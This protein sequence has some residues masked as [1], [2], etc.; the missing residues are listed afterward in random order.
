MK[1][2]ARTTRNERGQ[3]ETSSLCLPHPPSLRH[4][5]PHPFQH[6]PDLRSLQATAMTCLPRALAEPRCPAVVYR[7]S[8]WKQMFM[9]GRGRKHEYSRKRP[10]N[11]RNMSRKYPKTNPGN[12]QNNSQ[13]LPG[14][15]WDRCV[16]WLYG[17]VS[18]TWHVG[19]QNNRA[20]S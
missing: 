3:L 10:V 7:L 15:F 9:L 4:P 8:S 11:F 19:A 14:N 18:H 16:F 1:T 20:F 12:P 17:R 5:S 2:T 13:T 6:L